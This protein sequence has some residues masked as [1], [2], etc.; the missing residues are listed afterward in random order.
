M[1]DVAVIVKHCVALTA[2]QCGRVDRRPATSLD[3]SGRPLLNALQST[4]DEQY[5]SLCTCLD[6]PGS[7]QAVQIILMTVTAM[8]RHKRKTLS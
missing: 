3:T 2:M 1:P 6:E 4:L 8:T 5:I 7:Q